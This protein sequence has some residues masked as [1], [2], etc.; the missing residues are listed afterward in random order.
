VLIRLTVDVA[1][2]DE[3]WITEEPAST[4]PTSPSPDGR[5]WRASLA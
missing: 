3:V 2:F 1:R 5:S 4:P